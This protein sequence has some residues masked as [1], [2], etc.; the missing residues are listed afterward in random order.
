[1]RPHLCYE[2]DAVK[3][4]GSRGRPVLA[5][6]AVVSY[7]WLWIVHR[8]DGQRNWTLT[9]SFLAAR[10]GSGSGRMPVSARNWRRGAVLRT[11]LR[12]RR[13]IHST[14]RA[15]DDD[16]PMGR[17]RF[18]AAVSPAAPTMHPCTSCR[19]QSQNSITHY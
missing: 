8:S 14:V 1:M 7:R 12:L 10:L 4:A 6:P 16:A 11:K 13:P 18:K 5:R 3:A 19:T 15:V 9:F 17:R 2:G